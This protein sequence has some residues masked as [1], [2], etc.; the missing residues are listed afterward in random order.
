MKELSISDY[1]G[2]EKYRRALGL[3]EDCT[4]EYRV[5]AQ[6]EYNINYSFTH[7]V[8]GRQLVLRVNCGSQMHL[9]RQIEYEANALKQIGASGRTPVLHYVDGTD[10]APGNGVLVMDML[11]GKA[12]DY[13]DRLQMK[14]AAECLADIHSTYIDEAGTVRGNPEMV[15]DST[16]NLIAPETSMKAILEECEQMLKVYMESPLP[17][18]SRKARLRA[19]LDSAWSLI[20]EKEDAPYRCCINTELNSTNFLAEELKDGGCYVRLVDWEKP[21]YGDPAQ[22]LGHFL[23]PTTT[24]WKTDIIFDQ[25]TTDGFIQDYTEAAGGRFNT[26]GLKERTLAFI[27]VTC[28][29]GLTWCAMAWVQY[30]QADKMLINESTR[31]KLDQYLSDMFIADIE[32][33]VKTAQR[34]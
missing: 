1:I 8:S 26:E 7:P 34:G 27:P 10:I 12:L 16:V 2:T 6:G 19:L 5:L 13:T 22:D 15:P 9:S 21:L 28:L 18:E 30:H 31:I 11:P 23:A 20:P 3:P 25:E 14:G 32:Q 29:R 24:F 33:R 4:E 17:E